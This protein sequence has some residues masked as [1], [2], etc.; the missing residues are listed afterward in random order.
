MARLAVLLFLALVAVTAASKKQGLC[1]SKALGKSVKSG[2]KWTESKCIQRRCS[3]GRVLSQFCRVY[4]LKAKANCKLVE[5]NSKADYPGCCPKLQCPRPCFSKALKRP[6]QHGAKWTE[7]G[8]QQAQCDNGKIIRLPC[9]LIAVK[10]GCKVV[11]GNSKLPYPICCP[12]VKCPKPCFSK[13]LGRLYKNGQKWIEPGCIRASCSDGYIRRLACPLV[14]P[15]P[16][17]VVVKP[18]PKAKYP[19]CCISFKCPKPGQCYSKGLDKFFDDGAEWT[20]L[21]CHRYRCVKGKVSALTCPLQALPGPGCRVLKG[22][23]GAPYPSC[24]PKVVCRCYSKA[25]KRFFKDG[26]VWTEPPCARVTCKDGNIAA[27]GCPAFQA[28]NCIVKPGKPGAE[29]P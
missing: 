19:G 11:K 10:P 4:K 5:G 25:L 8:C 24:C 27:V 9:G 28:P 12:R 1:Y 17:C 22:K 16:G 13:P 3:N 15:G 14:R 18:N 6:F 29:L 20:E 23:T 21:P 2:F 26:A 7:P